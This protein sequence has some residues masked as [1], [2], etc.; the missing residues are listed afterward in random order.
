MSSSRGCFT[1]PLVVCSILLV[2][3]VCCAQRVNKNECAQR[4]D[5]L[6]WWF[7]YEL[8][9]MYRSAWH[10]DSRALQATLNTLSSKLHAKVIVSTVQ[11]WLACV[12]RLCTTFAF[13]R[14]AVSQENGQDIAAWQQ[15]VLKQLAASDTVDVTVSQVMQ[16]IQH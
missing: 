5:E 4:L 1:F 10:L 16:K 15:A 9:R 2:G 8:P 7:C 14:P 12:C 6:V 3:N 11:K 13:T